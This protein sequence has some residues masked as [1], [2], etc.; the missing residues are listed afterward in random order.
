[1]KNEHLEL[2]DNIKLITAVIK[3]SQ[4]NFQSSSFYFLLWGWVVVAANLGHYFLMSFTEYPHPYIVWLIVTPTW[5]ITMVYARKKDKVSKVV[6][7]IDKALGAMWIGFAVSV[8]TLILVGQNVRDYFNPIILLMAAIPTFVTGYTINFKPLLL[9]GVAFWLFGVGS[10]FISNEY[11]YILT[12]V[13]LIIG[14]L[15]PGHLLKKR[16]E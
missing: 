10:F 11:H 14:Y 6:T 15:I 4:G 1:M 9:G 2:G 8:F 12:P 3:N 5:I 16:E 13:A 7:H